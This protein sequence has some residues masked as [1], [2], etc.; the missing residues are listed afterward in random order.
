MKVST[1]LLSVGIV[2]CEVITILRLR[3]GPLD[4]STVVYGPW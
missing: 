1:L 3:K 2:V 4:D